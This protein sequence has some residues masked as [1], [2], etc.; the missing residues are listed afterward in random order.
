MNKYLATDE[1][2]ENHPHRLSENIRYENLAELL[3]E[4][5]AEGMFTVN[6]NRIITSWNRSMEQITGYKAS[7]AVG[8]NCQHFEFN[9]CFQDNCPPDF[10]ECGI[11]AIGNV[12]GKRCMLK[13]KE[14]HMVP[15]L[16]NAR[17][18]TD[19]EGN[20]IGAVETVTD[21]TEL[22]TTRL[23]VE[24][25]E[26]K[27]GERYQYGNIIGKSRAIKQVFAAIKAAAASDATILVEGESGTGKELVTGAIHH[28]S[29]RNGGPFVVVNCASL[30]ESL[31]ESE[32]YGHTKGA[33]TGAIRDRIG[34]FEEASGGTVFLDEIGEISPYMQIK[35]LRVLQERKI[36]RVGDSRLRDIDIRVIAAT[37][38]NLF[39]RVQNGLFREDLYYRLKVFPIRVP[40][41]RERKED[42]FLLVDHF[43]KLQ[44]QKTG[45]CLQ[46]IAANAMRLLMDYSWPGN[47]RELEN[48]IEHAFVLR[49]RGLIEVP[50]LPIEIR[51][52]TAP[53]ISSVETGGAYSANITRNEL[54]QLL[55]HCGWNKAAV[56][57]Q[58]GK[59]RTSVWKYMKKYAIPLKKE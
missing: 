20:A 18:I 13:H 23:K 33:F 21:L 10:K 11:F 51:Q 47:V 36:E 48:A 15:I 2:H 44:N 1:T 31:L 24:E 53:T 34:R 5:M 12:D 41:L 9:R 58:I 56:A 19:N 55:D 6:A 30:S 57:R 46:G 28:H 35:L 32:L 7:E 38:R 3:F 52:M 16:K 17:L 22:E 54:L 8:K 59:S 40:S 4:T 27:L 45:K 50:D 25:A 37:H 43:L 26:R 42:I 29:H 14:G 39:D 49:H